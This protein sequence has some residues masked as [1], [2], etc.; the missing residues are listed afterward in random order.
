MR[1]G[2]NRQ[3]ITVKKEK[4]RTDD[5]IETIDGEKEVGTAHIFPFRRLKKKPD[6][7]E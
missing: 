3:T 6:E 1:E 5:G 7:A 2:K 4:Q